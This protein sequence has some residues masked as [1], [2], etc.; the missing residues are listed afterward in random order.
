MDIS[1]PIMRHNKFKPI[2]FLIAFFFDHCQPQVFLFLKK[3]TIK[4]KF[5][6]TRRVPRVVGVALM[7]K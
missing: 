1:A 7:W 2:S 5:L 6:P 3:N 4:L